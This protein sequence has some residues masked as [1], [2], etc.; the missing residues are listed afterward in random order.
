V[1]TMNAGIAAAISGVFGLAVGS[2]LNVVIWRVPRKQSV[3]RPPSHCPNC[4][5][6]ISPRDNIQL[7]SWLVL[8]GRCRICGTHISGRYPLV[9]LLTG[10]MFALV[11]ARFADD[12]VVFAMLVLT[13]ALIALSAIDLEHLL[14]PNRIIYPTV[15]IGLPLFVLGA[16]LENDWSA[17]GRAGIGAVIAFV[18]FFAIWF[19]APRAMGYGD[20]RLAA[21]LGF[22]SAYLGWPVLGLALFLPFLLGSVGGIAIAAPIVL[23]PMAIGGALGY[24]GGVSVMSR[25]S[26]GATVTDPTQARITVALGTAIL[27]GAAVYLALSAMRRVERGRHIPFGPYLAA[28]ALLAILIHGPV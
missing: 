17:L 12:G 16:W 18:V 11:G 19:A 6:P 26:G 13:A 9:E 4:D 21:L 27:L 24:S 14:L 28:G 3:V 22:A 7:L 25:L 10:A 1:E 2:F 8:R 23:L 5:T 15:A 20:V